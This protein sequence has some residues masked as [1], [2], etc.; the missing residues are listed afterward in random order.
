[1]YRFV[2]KEIVAFYV[3][4]YILVSLA[5]FCTVLPCFVEFKSFTGVWA[6][7]GFVVLSCIVV[8]VLIVE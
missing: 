8:L 5:L 7:L 3:S 6:I 1:M 4:Q 2:K